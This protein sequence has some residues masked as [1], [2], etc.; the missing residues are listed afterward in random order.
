MYILGKF[1]LQ[2]DAYAIAECPHFTMAIVREEGVVTWLE[3][4]IVHSQIPKLRRN[5]ADEDPYHPPVLVK[6]VLNRVESHPFRVSVFTPADG[7]VWKFY[8]LGAW[9][10]TGIVPDRGGHPSE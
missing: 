3:L 5:V 4:V 10:L 7:H 2:R 6:L 1:F 9:S 8:R